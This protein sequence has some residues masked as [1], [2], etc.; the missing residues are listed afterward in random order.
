MK[1]TK[2]L[3]MVVPLVLN[4]YSYVHADSNSK[5]QEISES[6]QE[7]IVPDN[8]TIIAA[9]SRRE[10][11]RIVF[12]NEVDSVHSIENEIEYQVEDKDLFIRSA[13]VKPINIFVRAANHTYKL[14]LNAVDIPATQIFIRA[15]E[16]NPSKVIYNNRVLA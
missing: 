15:K 3:L 2:L 1:P 5:D 10:I 13:A 8:G 9:I 7:F 14:I 16:R 4:L 6:E 11:S 12:E